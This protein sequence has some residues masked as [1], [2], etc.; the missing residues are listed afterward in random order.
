LR[1]STFVSNAVA[2][3]LSVTVSVSVTVRSV[4]EIGTVMVG[5]SVSGL[6]IVT[7]FRGA[8][9]QRIPS[10]SSASSVSVA[11]APLRVTSDSPLVIV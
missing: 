11:V 10:V 2:S 3:S 8:C 6:S 9:V 1:V 7:V 4:A 5:S